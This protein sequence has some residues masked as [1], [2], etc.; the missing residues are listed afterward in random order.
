MAAPEPHQA[1]GQHDRGGS[2]ARGRRPTVPATSSPSDSSSRLP[3]RNGRLAFTVYDGNDDEIYTQKPN[4]GGRHQVTDNTTDDFDAVWSPG[5]KRIAYASYDGNDDEIYTIRPDG[6]GRHQVTDNTT[7]DDQP[8][9]SLNGKRIAYSGYDGNDDEIYTV[10]P[11]GGARRRVTDNATDDRN[12]AW[13]TLGG[14]LAY[15]GTTAPTTRST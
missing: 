8:S 1:A 11:D 5:A 4:G 9:W 15:R 10:N 6:G 12:P 2:G 13:S 3:G 7:D 14:Q